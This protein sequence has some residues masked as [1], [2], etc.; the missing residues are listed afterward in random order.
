MHSVDD[1]MTAATANELGTVI[2]KK[3]GE[4]LYTIPTSGVK[5]LYGVCP[6]H[7]CKIPAKQDGGEGCS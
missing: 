1:V 5:K 7:D 2:C 6:D 3:C 4:V